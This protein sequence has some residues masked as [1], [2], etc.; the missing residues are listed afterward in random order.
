MHIGQCP[1]FACGN[2][3]EAGDLAMLR[4]SQGS[5]YP[6]FLIINHNGSIR[7]YKYKEKDNLSLNTEPNTNTT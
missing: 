6:S 2:E 5:K 1:V 7:E 3:G 4:Y